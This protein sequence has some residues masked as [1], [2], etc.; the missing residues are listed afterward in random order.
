MDDWTNDEGGL[1][2]QERWQLLHDRGAEVGVGTMMMAGAGARD[3]SY[4]GR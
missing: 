2:G 4:F 1:R 3:Q